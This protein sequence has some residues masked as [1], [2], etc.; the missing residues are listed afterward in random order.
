MKNHYERLICFCC[1]LIFFV[2]V[3][4]PSTSFNV[5]QPYLAAEPALGHTGASLVLAMRSLVSFACMFFVDR[6]LAVLGARRSALVAT[7]F[8]STGFFV[9][10]MAPN[11]AVYLI[12]A[13]FAGAGY[14]LGGMVIAT[15]VT[16]RWFA[17]GVGTAM[18]I[19]TMGSGVSSF[20]LPP[21][22]ARIIESTSLTWGFLC[23]AL[24]AFV[25]GIVIFCFLRNNPSD[26][27]LTPYHAK[28]RTNKPDTSLHNARTT[29][30]PQPAFCFLFVGCML[31][32]MVAINAGSYFSVLFTSEGIDTLRAALLISLLG[33][34]L[35]L[36]KLGSGFL[37]D[38]IGARTST[39]ILYIMM[40]T[41]LVLA[42]VSS[43]NSVVPFVA[44][45][46]Y[47]FG[48]T[49][50]SVGISLWAMELST[51]NNLTST[52]KTMQIAYVVG[53]FLFSLVPGPLMDVCKTYVISY[54]LLALAA[55]TSAVIVVS[56]YTRYA[57]KK[58][59][60]NERV[61][62]RV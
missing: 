32:G 9:Y 6:F 13:A 59:R 62:E 38:R 23:E 29:P 30:L 60:P 14:G 12:G 36:G 33:L 35:T 57:P 4:L 25:L 31:L 44:V 53:G 51:P 11:L 18:G 50:G 49:L 41:G 46:I 8:T 24:L 45:I 17:S 22:V 21:I 1:F 20:L 10:A 26:L 52:V 19:A 7:L 16:R 43:A 2:N 27:G 56:V 47:G 58:T 3:G 15:L 34:A 39:I 55:F 37:F 5:F 61:N 28:T 48:I 54:A 40:T 42:C